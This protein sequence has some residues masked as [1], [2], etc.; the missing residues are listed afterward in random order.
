MTCRGSTRRPR[1]GRGIYTL[2]WGTSHGTPGLTP[3]A[4]MPVDRGATARADLLA[5]AAVVSWGLSYGLTKLA[6]REWRPLVFT[7]TRFLAMAVIA[8]IVLRRPGAARRPRRP[9][10]RPLRA[11]RSVRLH[12]LPARLHARAR[13]DL[14][15]GVDPAPHHGAPVLAAVPEVRRRRA[16][17]AEPVGGCR[18]RDRWASSLPERDSGWASPHRGARGRSPVARSRSLLR[19][20]RHREQAARPAV[21]RLDGPRRHPP[22]RQHAPGAARPRRGRR[23]V[24]GRHLGRGV[25]GLELRGRVPDLPGVHV[26]DR[27]DRRCAA[28]LPSRRTCCWSPSRAACSRCSGSARPPGGSAGGRG[29]HAVRPG[30][31]GAG[32]AA[33]GDRRR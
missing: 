28:S 14:R 6:F 8:L 25:G 5:V 32:P 18:A 13:A 4:R 24:V 10:S 1:L 9:R 23:A 3:R 29:A 26:V 30:R 16:G 20:L 11:G 15:D 2:T 12:P 22:R 17:R 7:G 19:P 27:R 33:T 21:S 31:A